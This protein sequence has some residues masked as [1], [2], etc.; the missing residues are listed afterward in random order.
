MA[1]EEL[2]AAKR[3]AEDEKAAYRAAQARAA[4]RPA[5]TPYKPVRTPP[6]SFYTQDSGENYNKGYLSPIVAKIVYVLIVLGTVFA[7]FM[8]PTASVVVYGLIGLAVWFVLTELVL[9]AFDLHKR[10]CEIRDELRRRP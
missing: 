7:M 3:Q 10:L 5:G 1:D 2:E 9:L 4:A 6:K 8:S